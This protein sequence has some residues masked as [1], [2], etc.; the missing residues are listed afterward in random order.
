MYNTNIYKKTFKH[1]IDTL[2]HHIGYISYVKVS[3]TNN[4]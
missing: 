1:P 4:I 3:Y 2:D